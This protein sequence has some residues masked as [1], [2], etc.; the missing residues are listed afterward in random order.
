MREVHPLTKYIPVKANVDD[1]AWSIAQNGLQKPVVLYEDQIIE[2]RVR[3]AACRQA[4]VEPT[5]TH[6]KG[7]SDVFDWMVREHIKDHEPDRVG[8]IQ[9]VASV[10]PYY[11]LASGSTDIRIRTA[12]GVGLRTART[13]A[14]LVENEKMT[15]AV[16]NGTESATSVALEHGYSYGMGSSRKT[17]R[18]RN[19][20]KDGA[21]GVHWSKGDRFD[22]VFV[23]LKKYLDGWRGRDYKFTH[24][25]PREARYRVEFLKEIKEGVEAALED[26]EPRS[27]SPRHTTR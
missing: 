14:W 1:V 2:G 18:P 23:P 10:A 16:L 6:W 4:G 24:V 11:K 20:K 3:Y 19:G 5:Y 12:T 21:G 27:V 9:L 22:E 17:G 25:N 7:D 15:P 26:L 8:M 13:I